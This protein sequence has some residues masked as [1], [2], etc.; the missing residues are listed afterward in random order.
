VSDLPA[1]G[2]D[3]WLQLGAAHARINHLEIAAQKLLEFWDSQPVNHLDESELAFAIRE[4]REV[5][6][7]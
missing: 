2:V 5:V 7:P 6:K 4:F 1:K 3:P